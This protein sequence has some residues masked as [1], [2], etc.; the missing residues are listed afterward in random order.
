[1][2]ALL[3]YNI[4]FEVY[5][6]ADF[7]YIELIFEVYFVVSDK[8]GSSVYPPPHSPLHI[9]LHDSIGQQRSSVPPTP[10]SFASIFSYYCVSW[11]CKV[12]SHAGTGAPAEVG[13]AKDERGDDGSERKCRGCISPPA[14]VITDEATDEAGRPAGPD[15]R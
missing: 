1:M 6:C 5:S 13:G 9:P 12:A 4:Y 10:P 15:D 14:K 2:C 11:C 3:L 7:L 8:Q